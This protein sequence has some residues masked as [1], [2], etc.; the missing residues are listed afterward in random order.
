MEVSEI[1]KKLKIGV[2]ISDCS[3]ESVTALMQGITAQASLAQCNL[4]VLT[5][6]H[7]Y[8]SILQQQFPAES[9]L[10][11]LGASDSF[12]G[13]IYPESAKLNSKNSNATRTVIPKQKRYQNACKKSIIRVKR[14]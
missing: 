9:E 10:L 7:G 5:S 3:S 2:I 12:D 6:I 8:H 13:Y 14:V 4:T 11:C 1:D